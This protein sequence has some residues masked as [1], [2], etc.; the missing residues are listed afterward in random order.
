MIILTQRFIMD[1][2][3]FQN[4]D[5]SIWFG[6]AKRECFGQ[7][8][9]QPVMEN[10]NFSFQPADPRISSTTHLPLCFA[11]KLIQRQIVCDF[12]VYLCSR[13]T[14]V[15]RQS[16]S[17]DLRGIRLRAPVYPRQGPCQGC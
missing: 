7:L 16:P 3:K 9:P 1:E 11:H 8:I 6:R 5:R 14:R 10:L 17:L 12:D 4:F 15:L 2:M 13:R